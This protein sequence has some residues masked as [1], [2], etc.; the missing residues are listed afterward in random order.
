MA[1]TEIYKFPIPVLQV[2]P[3]TLANFRNPIVGHRRAGERAANGE[4]REFLSDGH[5][6]AV[7]ESEIRK[8]SFCLCSTTFL[9]RS[10]TTFSQVPDQFFIRFRF[11]VAK[12]TDKWRSPPSPART[13]ARTKD[14]RDPS[15]ICLANRSVSRSGHSIFPSSSCVLLFPLLGEINSQRPRVFATGSGISPF[16]DRRMS[17]SGPCAH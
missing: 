1:L 7:V 2:Y 15:A 16:M 13:M 10:L 6:D 4:P 14:S 5:P 11:A 17:G 12:R 9:P 3:R 8:P